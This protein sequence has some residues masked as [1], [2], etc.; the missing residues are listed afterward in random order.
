M[1]D[2]C[3]IKINTNIRKIYQLAY[4]LNLS[5]LEDKIT[6]MPES[7]TAALV[8]VNERLHSYTH[9]GVIS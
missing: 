5:L 9:F 1:N 6:D 7:E 3:V 4:P 2:Y 8:N